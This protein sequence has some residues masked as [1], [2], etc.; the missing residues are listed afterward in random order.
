MVAS[1]PLKTLI[2]EKPAFYLKIYFEFEKCLFF[3]VFVSSVLLFYRW[4]K[5]LLC[6]P[7]PFW[8]PRGS[9]GGVS[10]DPVTA[11]TCSPASALAL[12]VGIVLLLSRRVRWLSTCCSLPLWSSVKTSSRVSLCLVFRP[13]QSLPHGKLTYLG[14]PPGPSAAVP[15]GNVL[16]ALLLLWDRL[17]ALSPTSQLRTPS[18]VF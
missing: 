10:S 18:L 14:S 2:L 3:T 7:G 13:W 15:C 11:Q 6:P 1:N 9:R 4:K 17:E 12:S 5:T 8:D 16:D